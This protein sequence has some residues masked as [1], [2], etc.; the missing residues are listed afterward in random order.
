MTTSECCPMLPFSD[1]ECCSFLLS[2]M[3][4]PESRSSCTGVAPPS[5]VTHYLF[6]S[7]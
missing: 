2:S 5:S 6:K 7:N 3:S 1:P 4:D